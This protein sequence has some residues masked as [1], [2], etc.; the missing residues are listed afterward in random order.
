LIQ[1]GDYEAALQ[2]A[3]DQVENGAQILDINLDD[4]LIDGK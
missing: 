4:G 1:K 3:K 2:V